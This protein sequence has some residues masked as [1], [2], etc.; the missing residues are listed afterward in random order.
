M[1][2]W[3]ECEE[4][5]GAL[6]AGG[7]ASRSVAPS[8]IITTVLKP[9]FSLRR[10]M[11]L[12]LPPLSHVGWL[13]S[14]PAYSPGGQAQVTCVCGGGCIQRKQGDVAL[15]CIMIIINLASHL[16]GQNFSMT[17]MCLR[18]QYYPYTAF[19]ISLK[20]IYSCLEFS[21]QLF[22]LKSTPHPHSCVLMRPFCLHDMHC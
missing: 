17:C 3:R 5:G 8:P 14:N 15:P 9:Y 2:A 22:I 13:S 12:P 16:E 11:T 21:F 6:T 10:L 1:T 19:K 20:N 4:R 7:H 18:D